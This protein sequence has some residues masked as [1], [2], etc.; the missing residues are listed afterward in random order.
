MTVVFWMVAGLTAAF[1][2]VRALGVERGTPMVQLV[3]YTPYAAVGGLA[4]GGILLAAGAKAPGLVC[5]ACGL[6]LAALVAPRLVPRRAAG[7]GV[8]LRVMAAN[9]LFGRG[10]TAALVEQV[11]VDDIDV[12]AVQELTAEGLAALEEAGI[13]ALLP[14][15]VVGPAPGGA[16]AGL[17]SRHPIDGPGVRTLDPQPMTQAW[18]TVLVPGAGPVAVES[19]HPYPPRPGHVGV[20][21]ANLAD[22]PVPQADGPPR[23]LLGDFNATL[24]HASLRRLLR[25]GYRDAAAVRGRGL[26]ATWPYRT[27]TLPFWTPPVTLDHVLADRRIG[28]REFNTRPTPNSDHRAVVA[29]LILQP[30]AA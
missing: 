28:V 20:W 23:V 2:A 25:A 24:D 22:Q 10:G 12:L 17:F 16:G 30:S 14:H 13:D 1:T 27:V 19:A 8:R 4:A 5:L 26:R 11:K 21:A 29:E 7:E 9:L 18:A 15:R 3:T 6:V